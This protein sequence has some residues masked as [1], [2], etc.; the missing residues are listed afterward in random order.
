MKDRTDENDE[1][2]RLD[3]LTGGVKMVS[4]SRFGKME[5]MKLNLFGIKRRQ[6]SKGSRTLVP[7]K[8]KKKKKTIYLCY[9]AFSIY[10][11]L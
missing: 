5:M 8:E 11:G 4:D 10:M 9:W 2:E 3:F 6:L 7:L 1:P